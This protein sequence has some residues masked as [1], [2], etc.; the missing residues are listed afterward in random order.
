M[1][2]I[3]KI[4]YSESDM[5]NHDSMSEIPK[6]NKYVNIKIHK[7]NYIFSKMIKKH[8]REYN[9][10]EDIKYIF[11]DPKL[12]ITITNFIIYNK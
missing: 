7:K 5:T 10:I 12:Q 4:F 3:L 2:I 9:Q 1:I 8:I 11:K 6:S